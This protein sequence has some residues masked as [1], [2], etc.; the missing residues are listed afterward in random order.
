MKKIFNVK[1]NDKSYM[2]DVEELTSLSSS[3]RE[4]S[5]ELSAKIAHA[6]SKKE[7]TGV[8]SVNAPLPGLI[9]EIFV[10]EGQQIKSGEKLLVLEAMKMEN[11]IL[12]PITGTVEK[13]S[14]K[15]GDSVNGKQPM[16]SI[17]R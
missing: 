5:P 17:K 14:V 4:L 12:A 16:I 9:V 8:M 10:K 6:S 11:S 7:A 13:I 2:V 15:V 1:V 3:K